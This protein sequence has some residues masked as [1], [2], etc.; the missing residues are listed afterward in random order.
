VADIAMYIGTLRSLGRRRV[1]LSS[2]R[3]DSPPSPYKNAR[4]E[5]T[6]VNQLISRMGSS[7]I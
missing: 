3:I 1:S 7:V 5:N 2:F 4:R 6:T